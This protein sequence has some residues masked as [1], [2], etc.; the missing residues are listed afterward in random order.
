MLTVMTVLP[1]GIAP[2]IIEETAK[3]HAD[4]LVLYARQF[5]QGGNLHAAEDVVQEVFHRLSRLP[6]LPENLAGWL[7]TAV[8]NGAISAAR[9]DKRRI[10]RE[11]DRQ[12]PLFQ[13]EA[14]S[15]FDTE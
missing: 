1:M 14:E 9:S 11:T 4:A 6:H 10:R 12:P 7:Y 8:R 3:T 5:F 13:T 15:P 2:T